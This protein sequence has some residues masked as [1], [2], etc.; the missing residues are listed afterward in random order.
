MLPDFR[1][2]LLDIKKY[3]NIE[4]QLSIYN[5]QYKDRWGIVLQN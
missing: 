2:V 3:F 4:Q 1:N 5:V